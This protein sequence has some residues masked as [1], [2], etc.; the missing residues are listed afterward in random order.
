M[1][2]LTGTKEIQVF[3]NCYS[4]P[5][6]LGDE[7]DLSMLVL[8]STNGTI[9]CGQLRYSESMWNVHVGSVGY[10]GGKKPITIK[11]PPIP[12]NQVEYWFHCP[13][14]LDVMKSTKAIEKSNGHPM[15]CRNDEFVQLS[16]R[17]SEPKR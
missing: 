3:D 16:L 14:M 10:V 2:V 6:Q 5:P 7:S 13:G 17:E 9:F 8:F 15:K 4:K 11:L 12:D 1:Q